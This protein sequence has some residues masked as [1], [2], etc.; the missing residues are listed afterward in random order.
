MQAWMN[1]AGHRANILNG[2]YTQLGVG[3]RANANGV[4][5][6]TEEFGSPIPGA[7]TPPPGSGNTP[8]P[9]P[10]TPPTPLA[11]PVPQLY[12]VGAGTGGGPR[13]IAYS[14]T[15][16]QKIFDFFAYT[17]SF[18][19]GVRVATGDVTGDGY[20]DLIVAPGAGGGPHVKAFDG[21]TGALIRELM[22]YDPAFT[23]GVYV[24]AGDVNGDGR[25]DI[26]TGTGVG[27]GPHVKAFSG[28]DG[29]V[30]ASFMAYDAA[31]TG[32]VYVAAGDTNGDGRADI[33]TGTGPGGGAHV[34]VFDGRSLQTVFSF[35]AFDPNFRGGVTVAAGDVNGDGRADV[36]A[37]CGPGADP[38]V[39]AFDGR[40]LSVLHDFDAFAASFTG[41]VR[42]TTADVNGDGKADLLVSAG[43]GLAPQVKAFSGATLA[44]LRNFNAFDPGF[45][46]GVYVG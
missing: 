45:L 1:S 27:G 21:R 6:F 34:K 46:G 8:P 31:F 28:R 36:I 20:D 10:V 24:A 30:L 33:V 7:A 9:P 35:F 23:G 42:L 2:S 43:A 41:G 22:A 19:G 17:T 32:G 40:N 3:V 4:L 15:T 26:V 38:H 29:A 14:A 5:Y 37:G 39:R 13:V 12:A 16:G 25:A 11:T 18:T 44:S